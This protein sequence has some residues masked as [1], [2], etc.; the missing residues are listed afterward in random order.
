[1]LIL[2]IAALLIIANGAPLLLS[3]VFGSRGNWRI[4]GGIHLPDDRP[5]FGATKTWRGLSASLLLTSLAAWVFGFSWLVGLAVA[6]S[7]MAGDLLSSFTKR[8]LGLVSSARAVGL[9]QLPES[10][11]PALVLHLWLG[12]SWSVLLAAVFLFVMVDI[13]MSP[14]LYRWGLRRVPH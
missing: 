9:D 2:G 5:L 7:A 6:A 1:M 3:N 12:F 4:D 8:R 14:L 10:L 13:G 11:L